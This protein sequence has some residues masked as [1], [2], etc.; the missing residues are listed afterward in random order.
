MTDV[1]DKALPIGTLVAPVAGTV[2]LT[3]GGVARVLV[4]VQVVITPATTVT[5]AGVPFV[6]VALV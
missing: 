3:V 5:A 4:N 1:A 2:E 6:Q